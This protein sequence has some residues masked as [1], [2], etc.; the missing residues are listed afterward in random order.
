MSDLSG[1]EIN[2]VFKASPRKEELYYSYQ[3][4]YTF[5]QTI[6]GSSSIILSLTNADRQSIIIDDGVVI[7]E[8]VAYGNP[9]IISTNGDLTFEIGGIEESNSVVEQWGGPTGN[10]AGSITESQL[11]V[12][13]ICR[14][15]RQNPQPTKKF[16]GLKVTN[17]SV[18]TITIQGTLHVVLKVYPK[19]L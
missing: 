17:P 9:T 11:A 4:Q 2:K 18:G 15:G 12:S 6:A 10:I 5:D 13:Q 7:A 3:A 19:F 1:I 8:V 16:L 14:Y